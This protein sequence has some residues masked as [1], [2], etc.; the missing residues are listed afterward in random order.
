[1]KPVLPLFIILSLSLYGHFF[2]NSLKSDFLSSFNLKMIFAHFKSG[3][4]NLSGDFNLEIRRVKHSTYNKIGK[5]TLRSLLLRLAGI[6]M[7]K[8]EKSGLI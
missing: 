5:F 3:E 6:K 1:M 7:V 4:L 2:S 8:E